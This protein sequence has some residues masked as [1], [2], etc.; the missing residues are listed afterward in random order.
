MSTPKLS[1]AL[2]SGEWRGHYV[3][4]GLAT[5]QKMVLEFADGLI[6]GDGVDKVSPFTIEGEYRMVEGETRMGWIKHYQN[7]H[8]ILYCGHFRE[9]EILG[10]WD[11]HGFDSGEFRL[12]PFQGMGWLHRN[13]CADF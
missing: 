1:T 12:Q 9:G 5:E 10:E 8:S 2:I 3:Q 13:F 6:R 4:M 11:L 7:G